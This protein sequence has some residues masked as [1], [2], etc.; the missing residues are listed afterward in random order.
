MTSLSPSINVSSAMKVFKRI[1]SER[2]TVQELCRY[3]TRTGSICPV[4][5]QF[6]HVYI[7]CATYCSCPHFAVYSLRIDRCSCIDV[8]VP[9]ISICNHSHGVAYAVTRTKR[10][11][12]VCTYTIT[13]FRKPSVCIM[14]ERSSCT[15]VPR[16][17][18]GIAYFIS[19]DNLTTAFYKLLTTLDWLRLRYYPYTGSFMTFYNTSGLFILRF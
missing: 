2:L 11:L 8:N 9:L 10:Y 19:I 4:P 7:K 1:E 6:W 17:S 5:A 12:C 16:A 18:S 13:V 3:W 14:S 15:D